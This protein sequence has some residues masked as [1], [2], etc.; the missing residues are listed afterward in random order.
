M[1]QTRASK[2]WLTAFVSGL[3]FGVGLVVGGMTDPRKVIAFLDIGGAWD[4]SLAF[5][6]AGA[7]AVHVIAYRWVRGNA[8]PLF[9]DEFAIPKLRHI[10]L[11]LVGGSALFG[12]GWGLGGY[13][14]GPSIVSLGAGRRDALVFV[15]AMFVGMFLVSRYQS[16]K[17]APTEPERD[18]SGSGTAA[19]R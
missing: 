5:V 6:M 14:P 13:C 18:L 12:V 9:A 10:D 19:A 3:V 1:S 4:P 15:V 17:G 11:A 16:W 8:A 2:Q 7:V